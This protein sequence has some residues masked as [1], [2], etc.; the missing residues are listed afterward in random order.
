MAI[1]TMGAMTLHFTGM[2]TSKPLTSAGTKAVNSRQ[3]PPEHHAHRDSTRHEYP[4]RKQVGGGVAY[5][6]G[7]QCYHYQLTHYVDSRLMEEI[8]EK[9][10]MAGGGQQAMGAQLEVAASHQVVQAPYSHNAQE[11]YRNIQ[12][13]PGDKSGHKKLSQRQKQKQHGGRCGSAGVQGGHLTSSMRH[14]N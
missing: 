13:M 9:D 7:A 10:K 12:Q 2:V 5:D 4:G 6:I 3:T 1:T 8:D 14:P 11:G